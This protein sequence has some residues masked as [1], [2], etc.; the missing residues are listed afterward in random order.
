MKLYLIRHGENQANVDGVM[1]YKVV[2][3]P[4]NI[5][6]V[7]QA[8]YLAEW[9]TDKQIVRVYSSPLNRAFQTAQIVAERLGLTD[10]TTIEELHE[11]N[12][13]VLD[14]KDDAASWKIHDL[15]LWR[16]MNNEP[17]VVFEGGEDHHSLR[18]RIKFALS[19]ILAENTDLS[20]EQGV[21]VVAHGGI[22]TLG[23][24]SLCT[25]LPVEQW[26]RGMG[27]T[28]VTIVEVVNNELNCLKWGITEHLPTDK[29]KRA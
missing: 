9:L 24:P 8:Q 5:K 18:A 15:I 13:G 29:P 4:L 25:N 28:A 19:Q 17:E 27:N 16:W 10:I 26:G 12:V 2:D 23:L 3:Y 21:A 11:I 6:G 22:F 20:D 1:A 14:G 7:Q